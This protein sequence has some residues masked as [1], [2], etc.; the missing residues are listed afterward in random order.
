MLSFNNYHQHSHHF[1]NKEILEMFSFQ[2]LK[3]LAFGLVNIFVPIYL[4][5]QGVPLFYIMLA[6]TGRTAL[7]S[8]IAL[9]FG[10]FVLFRLG[11]KHTFILTTI[12]YIISFIIIAQG[13]S[14][15]WIVLWVLFAGVANSFYAGAHHSYL[16][17]TLDKRSAGKEVAML[18]I[19]TIVVGII[20]PFVGAILILIFGF[21]SML[22]VGSVLLVVSVVPLFYSPEINILN[23]IIVPGFSYLPTFWREKKR[24][25][26]SV[27]GNGLDASHDPLW[28]PLYMYKLLGGIKMLGALASVVAFL[29]IFSHYIGGR[30]SDENK[31]DFEL[32]IK[33]SIFARLFTFVSFHPYIAIF[34]ETANSVIHPLFSMPFRAAFYKELRG[35]KTISYVVAHEVVWHTSNTIAMVI[36]SISVYFIGWYAFLVVGILMILGKMI[37]RSQRV[38]ARIEVE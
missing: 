15:L 13:T 34:S 19:L 32:G 1:A 30:R 21:Q 27:V 18:Y 7:H 26:W 11:I 8:I 36:L 16:A 33:G 3:E 25:A 17:L 20:T 5:I 2:V 9:F 14:F 12:L 31:S 35:V 28:Q 6:F 24:V 29:Q 22:F 10:R 23:Q 38:G 4:Y 37:I